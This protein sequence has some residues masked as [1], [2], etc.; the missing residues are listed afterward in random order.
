MGR[1]SQLGK[2]ETGVCVLFDEREFVCMRERERE[3]ERE[4]VSAAL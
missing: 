1:E 4:Y 2:R 3:R